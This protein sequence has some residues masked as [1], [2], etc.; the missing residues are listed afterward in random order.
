[1]FTLETNNKKV[2]LR[3]L[4][5]QVQYLTD[6]HAVNQGIAQW[7][8]KVIGQLEDPSELPNPTT[9]QGNY[10]DTYAVGT[11]PPYDFY[12]W[13][14]SSVDG[15][16]YWFNFGEISIVGPVGPKGDKGD[17][18]ETGDSTKWTV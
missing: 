3:N 1:M 8:I 4:E 14:R 15:I 9:Y 10:G 5:E 12:I 16:G 6:Y 18:G 7:G 13:T 17:K 2:D 11:E